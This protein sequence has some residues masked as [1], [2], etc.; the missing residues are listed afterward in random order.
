MNLALISRLALCHSGV[1]SPT[2]LQPQAG[3]LGTWERG[4]P[5]QERGTS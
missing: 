2:K 4:K 5:T 1:K 3:S